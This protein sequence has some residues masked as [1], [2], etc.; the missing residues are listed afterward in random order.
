MKQVNLDTAN[1]SVQE[2]VR[3]L[4]LKPRGWNWNSMERSCVR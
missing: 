2:F 3:N 1:Q 4:R